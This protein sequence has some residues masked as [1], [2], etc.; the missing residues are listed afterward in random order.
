MTKGW[1]HLKYSVRLR[2]R[3]FLHMYKYLIGVAK[4]DDA[5]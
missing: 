5:Q 2:E 1:G 4:Q 3:G